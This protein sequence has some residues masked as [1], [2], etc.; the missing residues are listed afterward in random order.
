MEKKIIS[1]LKLKVERNI[2]VSFVIY[3]SFKGG[4]SKIVYVLENNF[5]FLSM[6]F[7]FFNG[8]VGFYAAANGSKFID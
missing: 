8:Y 6:N 5:F 3:Q 4:L 1:R 7:H 2:K